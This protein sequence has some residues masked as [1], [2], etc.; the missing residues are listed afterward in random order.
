MFQL[1]HNKKVITKFLGR[2]VLSG[3]ELDH[4]KDIMVLSILNEGYRKLWGVE[5]DEV[6]C[7]V[8]DIESCHVGDD[9]RFIYKGHFLD[10]G[11]HIFAIM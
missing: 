9:L 7:I 5:D 11:R 10:C 3:T 2:D 6:I 4:I 1:K 8:N